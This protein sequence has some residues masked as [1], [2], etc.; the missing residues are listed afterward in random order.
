[1]ASKVFSL[2]KISNF[3][4]TISPEQF[5]RFC[6]FF[7]LDWFWSPLIIP[8]NINLIWVRVRKL[9]YLQWKTDNAQRTHYTLTL[10]YYKNRNTHYEWK[11]KIDSSWEK[12]PKNRL[13]QSGYSWEVRD[14]Y[15]TI[16][17]IFW[18]GTHHSMFLEFFRGQ[19]FETPL[20]TQK[21]IIG[22]VNSYQ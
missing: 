14:W 18:V 6:P 5:D 21:K 11:N 10:T 15:A 8:G 7:D 20:G 12:R 9:S 22:N 3:T 1:M 2:I 19:I 4:M 16:H 13:F 17:L